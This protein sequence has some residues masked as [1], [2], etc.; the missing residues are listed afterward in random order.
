MHDDLSDHDH[1]LGFD[2]VPTTS[3]LREARGAYALAIRAVL[4]EHGI[5]DVPPNSAFLLGGLRAG[6]PYRALARQRHH[7]IDRGGV[8]DALVGAGCV[9]RVDDDVV[10]TD[11]GR[12]VAAACAGATDRLD[13]FVAAT[14]GPDGYDAMRAGLVALIDWKEAEESRR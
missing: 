9:R 2:D 12:E 5:G 13:R 6:V 11:R 14:I 10:L 3:L 1:P 8:V 4:D 7:G